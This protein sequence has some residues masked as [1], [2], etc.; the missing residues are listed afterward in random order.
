MAP[1][2]EVMMVVVDKVPLAED[3]IETDE[4][5]EPVGEDKIA[6]HEIA[7]DCNHH[8]QRRRQNVEVHRSH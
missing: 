8:M 1:S 4:I 6:D 7:E 3:L 2:A 5:V